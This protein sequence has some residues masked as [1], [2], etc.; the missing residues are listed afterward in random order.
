MPSEQV[1]GRLDDAPLAGSA[2]ARTTDSTAS[3]DRLRAG[4]IVPIDNLK[5]VLVAWV[6][7]GHAFLAYAAFGGWPYD[8][9]EAGRLNTPTPMIDPSTNEMASGRPSD[10]PASVVGTS[11]VPGLR[12]EFMVLLCR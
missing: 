10:E 3:Q 5:A 4:R 1:L 8:A 7:A 11:V 2:P 6:I 9:S 12:L